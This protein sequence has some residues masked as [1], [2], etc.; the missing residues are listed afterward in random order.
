MKMQK[1]PGQL[2][3]ISSEWRDWAEYRNQQSYVSGS[4]SSIDLLMQPVNHDIYCSSG[5]PQLSV[6]PSLN[7]WGLAVFTF[8]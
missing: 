1:P 4:V 6:M 3:L 5:L 7:F 8:F 2:T